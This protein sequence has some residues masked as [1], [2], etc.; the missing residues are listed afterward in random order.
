MHASGTVVAKIV[1]CRLGGGWSCVTSRWCWT[2]LFNGCV[3]V[4]SLVYK[5][6]ERKEFE[7]TFPSGISDILHCHACHEQRSRLRRLCSAGLAA[8]SLWWD[9]QY[10]EPSTPRFEQVTQL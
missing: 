7:S 10:K 3:C 4:R 2:S 9:W 5:Y 6:E 1:T 8:T